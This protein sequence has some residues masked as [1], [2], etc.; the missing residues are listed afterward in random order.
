MSN[1][2]QVAQLLAYHHYFPNL[3]PQ[4][5]LL[6]INL[7]N[8]KW[9]A[10]HGF[11]NPVDL[12]WDNL[13]STDLK[14]KY[15]VDEDVLHR[16]LLDCNFKPD[17]EALFG[18]DVK[19]GN[20]LFRAISLEALILKHCYKRPDL[21]YQKIGG[22]A[23]LFLSRIELSAEFSFFRLSGELNGIKF[24]NPGH[25]L[26]KFFILY[27]YLEPSSRGKIGIKTVK[28]TDRP[29]IQFEDWFAVSGGVRFQ[30]GNYKNKVSVGNGS[31]PINY[32]D[33]TDERN[34]NQWAFY[35]QN[36]QHHMAT[37]RE[38]RESMF[39]ALKKKG[40][41]FER[42]GDKVLK[43]D[44]S[45]RQWKIVQHM[46]GA[47]M[48]SK[49]RHWPKLH[50][51]T[52]L[53]KHEP[54]YFTVA[55][56]FLYK[57]HEDLVVQTSMPYLEKETIT[58]EKRVLGM[59]PKSYTEF[60]EIVPKTPMSILLALQD[61]IE[62]EKEMVI[63][64]NPPKYIS[65]LLSL[66]D[67]HYRKA[68]RVRGHPKSE[69]SS[70]LGHDI[71]RKDMLYISAAVNSLKLAKENG[72]SDL[73]IHRFK[74]PRG[75]AVEKA[76]L[77]R[78]GGNMSE[79]HLR[80]AVKK[81][82][83]EY[84]QL[85]RDYPD[86]DWSESGLFVRKVTH[87]QGLVW[88]TVVETETKYVTKSVVPVGSLVFRKIDFAEVTR[89]TEEKVTRTTPNIRAA[90]EAVQRLKKAKKKRIANKRTLEDNEL[91]MKTFNQMALDVGIPEAI[92]AS[93]SKK[94]MFHKLGRDVEKIKK[95]NAHRK[96]R[97]KE[98][99]FIDLPDQIPSAGFVMD[100]LRKRKKERWKNRSTFLRRMFGFGAFDKNQSKG[101]NE[102]RYR[103]FMESVS[104]PKPAADFEIPPY[105]FSEFQD[106]KAAT[107]FRKVFWTVPGPEDK[108]RSRRRYRS[109]GG[110]AY[111]QLF[112]K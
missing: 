7:L 87:F 15:L 33:E 111:T 25:C 31:Y 12:D 106:L 36:Y 3:S 46:L 71:I 11:N 61:D 16:M 88:K 23:R 105:L 30:W 38:I 59:G 14:P 51:Y 97:L 52:E 24:H 66:E 28:G 58:T 37:D 60:L 27:Q 82:N 79:K 63:P 81:A 50:R 8:K 53:V 35:Y 9:C 68:L 70:I 54:E 67:H 77:E 6:S 92:K 101:L 17:L 73:E 19:M 112:L 109:A 72:L 39:L 62:K 40:L 55:D 18:L 22:D 78:R 57:L 20:N 86:S 5:F 83:E 21:F 100:E 26:K 76:I 110:L 49:Y 2:V 91:H 95:M 107:V 34:L 4:T 104:C 85:M 103:E 98:V 43:G 80:L 102:S 41:P 64:E 13:P 1:N 47:Y 48:Q 44:C 29:H 65:W 56:N 96:E 45:N 84:K 32:L 75:P 90:L 74:R 93:R 108:K 10:L 42:V 69:W 94:K 99:R 89:K